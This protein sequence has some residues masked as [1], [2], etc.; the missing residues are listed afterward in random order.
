MQCGLIAER[1]VYE[2]F[3]YSAGD[4]IG[5][6]GG[7]EG[8]SNDKWHDVSGS[9]GDVFVGWS[10]LTFAGFPGFRQLALHGFFK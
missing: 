7:G 8:M 3:D 6:K 4:K 10:G 9:K 1:L 5:M 2:P